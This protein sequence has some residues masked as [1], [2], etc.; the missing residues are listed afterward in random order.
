MD[1]KAK[2]NSNTTGEQWEE[3]YKSKTEKEQK[4]WLTRHYQ[5]INPTRM[6]F[7]KRQ[8]SISISLAVYQILMQALNDA[9]GYIEAL[10]GDAG[11]EWKGTWNELART[12]NA[13][14]IVKRYLAGKVKASQLEAASIALE[15]LY[16]LKF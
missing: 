8:G 13:S 2:N 15:Y 4:K 6:A 1:F 12:W 14:I 3:K 11:T 5:E 16:K 9:C 10:R 7:K